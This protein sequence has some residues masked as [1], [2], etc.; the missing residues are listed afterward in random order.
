MRSASEISIYFILSHFVFFIHF[1]TRS[2]NEIDFGF[3]DFSWFIP[4]LD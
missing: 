4:G 2:K 1:S 3:E